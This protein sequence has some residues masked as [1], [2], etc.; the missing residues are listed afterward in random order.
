MALVTE[1]HRNQE[2]GRTEIFLQNY[3]AMKPGLHEKI[4]G[5]LAVNVRMVLR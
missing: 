1:N 4:D 5:N 3:K 2:F